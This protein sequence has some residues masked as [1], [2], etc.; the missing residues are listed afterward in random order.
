MKKIFLLI[1]LFF[2]PLFASA[3]GI[4]KQDACAY[5]EGIHKQ[6]MYILWTGEFAQ[7]DEFLKRWNTLY[8]FIHTFPSQKNLDEY[9]ING[10]SS[11]NFIQN[12]GSYFVS[13]DCARSK[14]TFHKHI[15]ALGGTAY[16]KLNW[17][18]WQYLSY[19][20]VSAN[21]DPCSVWPDTILDVS[22]LKVLPI[23]R[24]AGIPRTTRDVCVWRSMYRNRQDG[25]VQF[26]IEQHYWSS[27]ESYYSR[28]EY[29]FTTKKL[30][31]I[32]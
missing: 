1:S 13:F 7:V 9:R 5:P 16:G 27:N 3:A 25:T 21:R 2:F 19:S 31:K 26:D 23:D 12:S 24:I 32:W 28:Y 18:S 15:R 20:L 8:Y 29:R 6:D 4:S 17:I 14:V 10:R 30:K 11:G 22:T